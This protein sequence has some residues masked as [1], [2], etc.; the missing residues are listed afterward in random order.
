MPFFSIIKAPLAVFI[1]HV[2]VSVPPISIYRVWPWFDVPM[3]FVGGVSIGF[4]AGAFLYLFKKKHSIA[5]FSLWL[6][7]FLILSMTGLAVSV[8]ELAE[9]SFTRITDIPIQGNLPDTM[10]DMFLGLLGGF[11]VSLFSFWRGK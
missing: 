5:K 3:H 1:F 2:F 10:T 11:L 7:V 9:F 4:A 8:W 6:W